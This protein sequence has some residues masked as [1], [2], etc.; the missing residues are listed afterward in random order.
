MY[1]FIERFLETYQIVKQAQKRRHLAQVQEFNDD[2]GLAAQIEYQKLWP[3]TPYTPEDDAHQVGWVQGF[4]YVSNHQ[5]LDVERV[6][7]SLNNIARHS[8]DGDTKGR[9]DTLRM[10]IEIGE[11]DKLTME[12]KM[13]TEPY[14]GTL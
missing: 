5:G 13:V 8:S 3:K 4:A 9:L 10:K 6:L 12:T 7:D 11:Y 14:T 2:G 1:D